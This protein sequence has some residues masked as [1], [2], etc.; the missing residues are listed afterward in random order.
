MSTINWSDQ[1]QVNMAARL[2]LKDANICIA[3]SDEK[4]PPFNMTDSHTLKGLAE[5]ILQLQAELDAA[6]KGKGWYA[7]FV[8]QLEKNIKLNAELNKHVV[9]NLV[10]IDRIHG[11]QDE[12]EMYRRWVDDLQS[13]MYI[14]CVYCGHRYGN[15]ENTQSSMA[16]ILKEHVE[17]C[18][19]HPMSKLKAEND[20][21]RKDMKDAGLMTEEE[22]NKW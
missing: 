2:A 11:L 15:V 5:N 3:N 18:P 17:K 1:E 20:K 6:T 10:L 22:F 8:K 21:L 14:N 16:D 7:R 13:G 12:L 9:N 19:K 4:H